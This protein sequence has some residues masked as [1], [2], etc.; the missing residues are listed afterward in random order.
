MVDL[1]GHVG[2]ALA[3]SVPVWLKFGRKESLLFLALAAPTALLPD[4]DLFL[5][6]V[7]PVE[8]HGITHTVAFAATLALVL[9]ALAA[10]V[11]APRLRTR[12]DRY[13]G[14]QP[15]TG[16]VFTFSALAFFTGASSHLVADIFSAPDIAPPVKPFLPFTDTPV[17]VDAIYYD[18]V[19]W[20]FGLLGVV[21]LIHGTI[22]WYA[23]RAVRA[24]GV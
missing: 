13:L 9:G 3:L 21:L 8:H 12:I 18:A 6:A 20:N 4:S 16:Q 14:G 19:I 10:T 15:A 22:F 11:V 5:R 17:I 1:A 24:N 2:F 23:G 7:F